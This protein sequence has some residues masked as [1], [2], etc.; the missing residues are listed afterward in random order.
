MLVQRLGSLGDDATVLLGSVDLSNTDE[1]Q[2][3][4]AP[5]FG[6]PEPRESLTETNAELSPSLSIG[7]PRSEE[8]DDRSARDSFAFFPARDTS[9]GSLTHPE[10]SSA[11]PLPEPPPAAAV[12]DS[13]PIPPPPPVHHERHGSAPPAELLEIET[14]GFWEEA[15]SP[16][17]AAA[18]SGGGVWATVEDI[19]SQMDPQLV[20]G[21]AAD[22]RSRMDELRAL[23]QR[24]QAQSVQVR[25]PSPSPLPSFSPSLATSPPVVRLAHCL[26]RVLM[27]RATPPQEVGIREALVS[28]KADH[29]WAMQRAIDVSAAVETAVAIEARN[30]VQQRSLSAT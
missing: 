2:A 13:N 27:S 17:A 12:P 19:C 7:S 29:A 10:V 28:E 8:E 15:D 14:S 9:E 4:E 6:F 30:A 16:S 25:G 1:A 11:D 18:A 3:A 20:Q 23:L 26:C 21:A 24:H 5:S 22:V